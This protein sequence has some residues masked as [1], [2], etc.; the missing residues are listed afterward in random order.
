MD[1]QNHIQQILEGLNPEQRAATLQTEGPVLVIAGA[2]S[3]KTR[4]LTSRMAF[5]LENG[6][7]PEQI[8]A[9]TFTNKAAS[10]MK[11]RIAAMSGEAGQ[12]I[13]AGTFHSI[14]VRFLRQYSEYI[15]FTSRFTIY[16]ED[17]SLACLKD[18]IGCILFGPDYK[19]KEKLKALTDDQ[20]K[21]RKVLMNL[22]RPKVIMGRISAAKNEMVSPR[23]YAEDS[24]RLETDRLRGTI[25]TKDIYREYM[26]RCH[27]A[28]AMDF[29]DILMYME[30]LLEKY[31]AIR[32]QLSSRFRYILVDE[33][34]DT[35]LVQYMIIRH[36]S[37]AWRNICA[38]GDDSQSIYAFR[39]A[40]IQNILNF[41]NDY[42]DTKTFRLETN[43]RST[44]EIVSA[45]NRLI[46]HNTERLPKTCR[47]HK[48]SG[49]AVD[50]VRCRD[51]REE[52]RTIAWRI[53]DMK[54]KTPG[55][56]Y[57]DFAVLY[58]TNAQ[59]RELEDA[60]I[61]SR[62]PYRI[63]SGLSFYERTE[64]KDTLA[65]LRLTVNPKDDESFKR[66]C[67]KPA[68][69]F[70]DTTLS[71]IQA[72]AFSKGTSLMEAS[73]G[74]LRDRLGLKDSAVKHVLEFVNLMDSLSALTENM[75]A[76]QA[77]TQ[78]VEQTGIFQFYRIQEEDTDGTKRTNNISSLL[79]GIAD[80][81]DDNLQ[82]YCTGEE[83]AKNTLGDYI[84]QVSLLSNA[85][86]GGDD[87]TD[88]VNLMTSHCSKGLE[89]PVVFVAGSEEGLFPLL[90]TDSVK[91]DEEEERRLY[92]VSITRAKDR[93]ILTWCK[94]RRKF[95]QYEDADQSRFI[96]EMFPEQEKPTAPPPPDIEIP[97]Q[98]LYAQ[99]R[100]KP[101]GM[102]LS[103]QS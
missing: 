66:I 32:Q 72:E 70:S 41:R 100:K 60:F 45:A 22:Y 43:Y 96:T 97:R 3:G 50:V 80:F 85:D 63:F 16:D 56:R 21:E 44:P 20:K 28:D 91:F 98:E 81:V 84:E 5:L 67:N 7:P 79:N 24:H 1:N 75:D 47:A 8:L 99:N 35:N 83:K 94:R 53:K 58:R 48:E 31:P 102:Y 64:V 26:S 71:V 37:E 4:M 49:E 15:G 36:L 68:R 86:T 42:P 14:F 33:Y 76:Y 54:G 90:M 55:S 46:A 9:L 101:Y 93:L 69:G 38:V 65:Y 88:R 77:A 103:R 92:Y 12:R 29:D 51:D 2:G 18:C 30:I 23:L 57:A 17:D 39:G 62:I 19:D 34:Q 59:S 11:N 82:D 52:A 13:V 40:R 87:D 61:E 25:L 95:G 27:K 78:I 6:V 10:E 74:L 73:R 89:F